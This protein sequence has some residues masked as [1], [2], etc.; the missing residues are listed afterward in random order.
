MAGVNAALSACW[1]RLG[2]AGAV[3]VEGDGE[4]GADAGLGEHGC[5]PGVEAQAELDCYRVQVSRPYLSCV[6]CGFEARP[7]GELRC[8]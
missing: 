2:F 6:D 8:G 5:G 3:A 7:G 1:W 4:V